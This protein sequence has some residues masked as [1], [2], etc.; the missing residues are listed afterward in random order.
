MK[1]NI[2]IIIWVF[3]LTFMI[4]S[5]AYSHGGDEAQDFKPKNKEVSVDKTI[6]KALGIKTQVVELK[7]TD[8][9]IVTT[10]QIEEIPK[11]HF[12]INTPVQG[13]VSSLLV[14]IGSKI[15]T[16]QSVATIQSTEIA[17]LQAEIDQGEA[18]LELAQSNFSRE[19]A[20]FQKGISAKK[21]FEA[22]KALLKSTEAKLKALESNL[23]ILTGLA[24]SDE[25]GTFQIKSRKSGT[26]VERPI[27]IGQVVGVN[28]LLFHA[29][30]LSKLWAS[31]NIYEKDINSVSIGQNVLVSLDGNPK[32]S[33]EGKL[34]YIGS[35]IDEQ[36]RTLPVKA[37]LSNPKD[38][39]KPGA[40]V[41]LVIHTNKKKEAILIPSAAIVDTDEEKDEEHKHIVYVKE[42]TSY[43]PRN[44]K[45]IKHDKKYTEVISGLTRGDILVVSGGYQL[46]YA[47]GEHADEEAAGEDHHEELGH[48]HEHSKR[49][50]NLSGYIIPGVIGLAIGVFLSL[51]LR[52]KKHD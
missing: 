37:E 11:N 14:D 52:R 17:K 45:V 43:K 16:G 3:I 26:V 1:K 24:T 40:F 10:G 31:A 8:E 5:P 47:H 6:S 48:T 21:D 29:I 18:E 32:E 20:L 15:G 19:E 25:Q 7:T 50:N 35:V 33:Y 51:L 41:Q 39:L 9:T 4:S 13:T 46:Q 49:G 30:D 34:T 27:N 44:I 2:K 28:Q 23:K 38:V 12:D 42:G 22:S 36:S